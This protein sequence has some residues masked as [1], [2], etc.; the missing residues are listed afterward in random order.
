MTVGQ[1]N[2][3]AGRLV[4]DDFASERVKK[5]VLFQI[6]GIGLALV[7]GACPPTARG[8]SHAPIEAA[9][10]GEARAFAI[11][12]QPLSS[13]VEAFAA[14]TG[15]QVLYDQPTGPHPQSPGVSGRFTPEAALARLLVGTGLTAR[16][17]D[18]QDVV[19][20]S[21]S[22]S[23]GKAPDR[24]GP[25][26]DLPTL[27]LDPLRVAGSPVVEAQGGGAEDPRLYAAVVRNDVQAALAANPKTATG[28]YR[29]MI[30]VW[31]NAGAR[32]G[33]ATIAVS[34]GDAT[35]D[36]AIVATVRGLG[37]E[38]PPPPGLPQPVRLGVRS[39]RR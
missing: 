27:S 13:A 37:V 2:A 38:A 36:L 31:I 15:I 5:R 28:D 9:S 22:R 30:D 19:L 12:P 1:G 4:V 32:I 16:F 8:E 6:S 17:T 18:P 3:S 21:L 26:A 35:R 11:A 33:R 10:A 25:P 39:Q 34:S 23:V 24:S 7:L 14:V 20:Q 29:A